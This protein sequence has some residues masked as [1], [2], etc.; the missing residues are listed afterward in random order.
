MACFP[1]WSRRRMGSARSD[2]AVQSADRDRV[3]RASLAR[4]A[5]RRDA[6]NRNGIGRSTGGDHPRSVA[7]CTV[8]ARAIRRTTFG[9]VRPHAPSIAP[10]Q[11]WEMHDERD[12][13]R[14]QAGASAGAETAVRDSGRGAARR[15]ALRDLPA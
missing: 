7:G 3:A 14:G 9:V 15:P 12:Q 8:T 6:G 11:P 4:R 2:H 13:R 5:R 1:I 10:V